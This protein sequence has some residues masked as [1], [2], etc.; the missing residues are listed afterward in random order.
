MT[1]T[2]Q[3]QDWLHGD[4]LPVTVTMDEKGH[5]CNTSPSQG[6]PL[7]LLMPGIIDLHAVIMNP[8]AEEKH[9]ANMAYAHGITS[10]LAMPDRDQ[11]N[12]HHYYRLPKQSSTQ[13]DVYTTAPLSKPYGD[14][15]IPLDYHTLRTDQVKALVVADEDLLHTKALLRCLQLVKNSGMMVIF[16]PHW[17]PLSQTGQVHQGKHAAIK[18]L[19]GI[20]PAAETIALQLMLELVRDTGTAIHCTGISSARSMAI[21]DSAKKE[22]LPITADVSITHLL[23]I[24]Q[25]IGNFDT[26]YK[27]WPPLR[28]EEDRQALLTGINTGSIDA[29][30]SHHSPRSH[31]SKHLPFASASYGTPTFHCFLPML[32]QLLNQQAITPQHIRQCCHVNPAKILGIDNNKSILIHTDTS[33]VK[34]GE[35][36]PATQMISPLL[37]AKK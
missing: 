17:T 8:N 30:T 14:S 36:R 25:D 35:E 5:H 24:D 18:G 11:D 16:Q 34:L 26:N 3:A 23:F 15:R 2:I 28:S 6:K 29:I 1:S 32:T 27:L 12:Q 4:G 21:I 13:A 22:G 31:T 7:T 33:P 19:D 37:I 9:D 20:S 10:L